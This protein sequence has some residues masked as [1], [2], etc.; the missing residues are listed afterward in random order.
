MTIS[1]P[2]PILALGSVLNGIIDLLKIYCVHITYY[3]ICIHVKYC[4]HFVAVMIITKLVCQ[5]V[6]SI[7]QTE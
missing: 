1:V 5:R 7:M 2:I 4:K 6:T 3:V